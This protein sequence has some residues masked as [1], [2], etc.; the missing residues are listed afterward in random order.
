MSD[1]RH[2]VGALGTVINNRGAVDH[3]LNKVSQDHGALRELASTSI[4]WYRYINSYE[5]R[6]LATFTVHQ[7]E[8]ILTQLALR[9]SCLSQHYSH[10]PIHMMPQDNDAALKKYI[11]TQLLNFHENGFHNLYLCGLTIACLGALQQSLTNE[12]LLKFH[13]ATVS[14]ELPEA[15]SNALNFVLTQHNA[16]NRQRNESYIGKT[17]L[18]DFIK[19]R[20]RHVCQFVANT[21]GYKI[22]IDPVYFGN[23]NIVQLIACMPIAH[24]Q[25]LPQ[26]LFAEFVILLSRYQKAKH[27]PQ[28][29]AM[30]KAPDF[31]F[32][33]ADIL[34]VLLEI[35][36]IYI[37][38]EVRNSYSNILHRAPRLA[39]Q[40]NALDAN[41]AF[42]IFLLDC[43]R[44]NSVMK[45]IF[46]LM[47][48]AELAR[49]SQHNL[50]ELRKLLISLPLFGKTASQKIKNIYSYIEE[51]I[52]KI[53]QLSSDNNKYE[54]LAMLIRPELSYLHN[55]LIELDLLEF[56]M[57]AAH[58]KEIFS[59]TLSA[60]SSYLHTPKSTRKELLRKKF[61]EPFI[62]HVRKDVARAVFVN[63]NKTNLSHVEFI[64]SLA[65]VMDKSDLKIAMTDMMQS[66]CGAYHFY[67][68]TIPN[69]YVNLAAI[70]DDKKFTASLMQVFLSHEV[71]DDV[72]NTNVVNSIFRLMIQIDVT[73]KILLL[74][75]I[76]RLIEAIIHRNDASDVDN[77][78]EPNN[79]CFALSIKLNE[80]KYNLDLINIPDL[81][82]LLYSFLDYFTPTQAEAAAEKWEVI[83]DPQQCYGDKIEQNVALLLFRK[84][85]MKLPYDVFVR[86][87]ESFDVETAKYLIPALVFD[88]LV[89]VDLLKVTKVIN[90]LTALW[91]ED[92][93]EHYYHQLSTVRNH[94]IRYYCSV[95]PDRTNYQES[96]VFLKSILNNALYHDIDIVQIITLFFDK[97]AGSLNDSESLFVIDF[98]YQSSHQD[99]VL[100]LNILSKLNNVNIQAERVTAIICHLSSLVPQLRG[101]NSSDIHAANITKSVSA[102]ITIVFEH[103]QHVP[104]KMH[105]QLVDFVRRSIHSP[106]CTSFIPV[107]YLSILLPLFPDN[108]FEYLFDLITHQAF[109]GS[110]LLRYFQSEFRRRSEK[111]QSTCKRSWLVMGNQDSRL[112]KTYYYFRDTCK[113]YLKTVFGPTPHQFL[114]KLEC[115]IESNQLCRMTILDIFNE[116]KQPDGIYAFMHQPSYIRINDPRL[117]AP[118]S[119]LP[120]SQKINYSESYEQAI[121]LLMNAY[122]ALTDDNTACGRESEFI[123]LQNAYMN[124]TRLLEISC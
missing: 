35:R 69:L 47:L 36:E 50:N 120:Y 64:I 51:C 103:F 44:V 94:L 30:I 116:L 58:N 27:S 87:L 42:E 83:F 92:L 22:D 86:H 122:Q 78:D 96:F 4:S 29:K 24:Y 109:R 73:G 33:S 81:Y 43:K 14:S 100:P 79:N 66:D 52:F 112:S 110:S 11:T 2:N 25:H 106:L 121:Y 10:L 21:I 76:S 93:H 32:T 82:S 18:N 55:P 31:K 40:L 15:I 124:G 74:P 23:K 26:E 77:Q 68:A 34:E 38:F 1:S 62:Q 67:N 88:N 80:T 61:I 39:H 95:Q 5:L 57:M 113:P 54:L 72:W 48:L 123:E 114:T 90:T 45:S 59:S 56:A 108:I 75:V 99:E 12:L 17:N 7:Q 60:I 6:T 107:K 119:S 89:C 13:F 9:L 63:L 71:L 3:V 19:F 53:Y 98:I 105:Y 118:R 65:K 111:T 37:K 84:L 104:A 101:L 115:L 102:A 46:S 8:V 91:R 97:I 70:I 117:F 20:D 41:R 49:H 16:R 28:P 85:F